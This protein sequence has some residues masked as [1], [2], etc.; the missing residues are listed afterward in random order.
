MD[1]TKRTQHFGF[2]IPAKRIDCN[3]KHKKIDPQKLHNALSLRSEQGCFQLET[4]KDGYEHYQVYIKFWRDYNVLDIKELFYG[5]TFHIE[6][7]HHTPQFH[8]F[9]CMKDETRIGRLYKWNN[10]SG[11]QRT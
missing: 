10:D 5:S 6:P 1:L 11:L 3:G 7:L 9:Y 2:T 8:K 4:G